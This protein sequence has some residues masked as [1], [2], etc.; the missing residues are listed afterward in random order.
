MKEKVLLN[1]FREYRFLSE[2][3]YAPDGKNAALVVSQANKKNGYNSTIWAYRPQQGFVKMTSLGKE[4]G[5]LWLD[6]RTILF[7]SQRDEDRQK[8]IQKGEEL[9]TYY[10]LSLDGG[11]AQEA[12]TIGLKVGSLKKI[13]N[14]ENL[15]LVSATVDTR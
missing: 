11:E 2:L 3:E 9:T 10:K 5:I 15:Y 13:P 1:D 12:F 6:N 4:K 7:A 8:A 14:R